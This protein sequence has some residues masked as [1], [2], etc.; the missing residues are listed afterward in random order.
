MVIRSFKFAAL[1]I[2]TIIM[3]K[4]SKFII[5]AAKE[6]VEYKLNEDSL[7]FKVTLR[8][9]AFNSILAIVAPIM[10]YSTLELIFNDNKLN[11]VLV[12]S[13]I[14]FAITELAINK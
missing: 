4:L 2:L 10:L 12:T 14:L 7:I 1:S 11:W 8:E 3:G 9:P 6:I 5:I 13:D